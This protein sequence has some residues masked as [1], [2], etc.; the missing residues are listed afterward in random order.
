[1]HAASTSMHI[2]RPDPPRA[3]LRVLYYSPDSFGV[4]H[5]RR[6]LTLA[7]EFVAREEDATALVVSGSA[8]MSLFRLPERVSAVKLP[9]ITKNTA[10]AYVSGNQ[11]LALEEVS[12]LRSDLILQAY[13]SFRPDAVVVDHHPLGLC[14]EVAPLLEQAEQDG[15]RR[16]LGLRDIIDAPAAVAEEWSGAAIREALARRYH[17]VCVYG[18]PEFFDTRTEYP[19][20]S[21]LAERVEFTGYV[22][23]EPAA[24]LARPRN[25]RERQVL[26]TTGGGR[27]GVERVELYLDAIERG[28]DWSSVVVLGPLMDRGDADRLRRRTAAL[29][30]VRVHDEHPDLPLLLS[31][32]DAVVA[33]A[34]YNTCTEIVRHRM[35][36]V[37]L[38]RV[39]PREEQ[40]IR[41]ERLAG[42]GLATALLEPDADDLR[43]AVAAS[44][45]SSRD[46]QRA[47]RLD[48]S[49]RACDILMDELDAGRRTRAAAHDRARAREVS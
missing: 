24:N 47:P 31:D 42:L 48:G 22:V 25:S 40:K 1:M 10:G 41:A 5:L 9:T 32:C 46:W 7:S 37:L 2:P 19:V 29:R 8:C 26:V 44:L 28:A 36:S 18:A 33:M 30:N 39:F 15:A 13:R 12:Q 3:P 21:E 20:P 23:N 11:Q 43:E 38:P 49:A 34:G 17:R 4:G 27:D 35:P 6:T 14:G 16:I 45:T